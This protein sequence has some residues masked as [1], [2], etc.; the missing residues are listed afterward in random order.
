M[1]NLMENNS[2]NTYHIDE[3]NKD[4]NF[5]NGYFSKAFEENDYLKKEVIIIIF[6]FLILNL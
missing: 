3:K 5:F 1:K 2:K 6:F 4:E